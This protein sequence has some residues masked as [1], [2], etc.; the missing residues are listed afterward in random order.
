LKIKHVD[1][2]LKGLA[3]SIAT[4]I[5][6]YVVG[7]GLGYTVGYGYVGIIGAFLGVFIWDIY[8]THREQKLRRKWFQPILKRQVKVKEKEVEQK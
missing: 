2:D 3:V 7:E 5:I 6:S 1:V 8:R 4:F